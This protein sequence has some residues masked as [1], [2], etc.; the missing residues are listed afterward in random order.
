MITQKDNNNCISVVINMCNS[1]ADFPLN[2]TSVQLTVSG[3]K[4]LLHLVGVH[5]EQF[6]TVFSQREI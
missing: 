6:K 5:V 3:I 2:H 4:D 1:S